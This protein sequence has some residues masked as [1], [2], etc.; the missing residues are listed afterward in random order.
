MEE[1]IKVD[2]CVGNIGDY[3]VPIHNAII[4]PE[5]TTN[6]DM[7][8]AMLNPYKICEYEYSIHIYMTE[9]DFWK[10]EYQMNCDTKWWN[11][12]YGSESEDICVRK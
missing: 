10:A 3:D 12:P 11:A 1:V 2:D 7:I 5:N 4:V 8:K 9:E 6:G